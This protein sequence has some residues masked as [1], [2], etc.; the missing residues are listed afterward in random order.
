MP[1]NKAKTLAA[2]RAWE[3]KAQKRQQEEQPIDDNGSSEPIVI[4]DSE[5]DVCSWSGGVI[6]TPDIHG[7]DDGYITVWDTE[8]EIE[9]V[10][11]QGDNDIFEVLQGEEV[12]DGLQKSCKMQQ[13][14]EE[15]STP[16][17][18]ER[19]MGV[20]GSKQW[21]KAESNRALGYN[22][23]SER[24]KREIRQE[25]REKEAAAAKMQETKMAKNFHSFFT[26]APIPP[27]PDPNSAPEASNSH[28]A[29]A[30]ATPLIPVENTEVFQGYLSDIS[31]DE[32]MGNDEE[33]SGDDNDDEDEDEDTAPQAP[34]VGKRRKL[35]VSVL[36]MRA[37]NREAHKLKQ[38]RALEDIE[39]L[40][41]SKL[42]V[43]A[44][45]KNS[46][47]AY[48]ARTIQSCLWMMLKGTEKQCSFIDASRR[49]AESHK[50]SE[51][52]GGRMVRSWVTCWINT[53]ELPSSKRGCH[54]KVYSLLDDPEI[55]TELHSY[56]R[57]NKWAIDPKKL[58]LFSKQKLIPNEASKCLHQIVNTEMPTG[59]KKYM[60]L[61]LFPRIQMKVAKG[62][63]LS[64]ACCWLVK[65]G[66]QYTAHKKALY[67][68]GHERPDVVQYRQDVFVPE[69]RSYGQRLVKY[70]VGDVKEEENMGKALASVPLETIRK[71]EHRMKRWLEA[72]GNGLD[73]KGAEKQVRKFSSRQTRKSNFEIVSQCTDIFVKAFI[74]FEYG[75][76]SQNQA[77]WNYNCSF[78]PPIK[79]DHIL[80]LVLY[81]ELMTKFLGT[82]ITATA[83]VKEKYSDF[84]GHNSPITRSVSSVYAR[85]TL[86]TQVVASRSTILCDA[87]ISGSLVYFLREK[88]LNRSM[89][90]GI[91]KI[92]L[93]SINIGLVTVAVATIFLITWL[94]APHSRFTW[95]IFF[96]PAAPIY[97]NSVLVSLNA[98]K[99]IRAQM[100]KGYS[101]PHSSMFVSFNVDEIS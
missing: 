2:A 98:R 62:V 99:E 13:D 28:L 33:G 94:A 26:Q 79:F 90:I 27:P 85:G 44:A 89:R 11:E 57:S 53:R 16:T 77:R 58:A 92:T 35:N 3:G 31:D 86:I 47:Q 60:E 59:L 52:W 65:E 84:R 21:R 49:A 55:C 32:W 37:K 6:C 96:Y 56:I 50:L 78:N 22:G 46:L 72:Y 48:R 93:Y 38:K 69:M 42:D 12:I 24:R 41:A 75:S 40:I 1:R 43:F 74:P 4:S 5:D 54:S 97:V 8:E 76:R 81:G 9:S 30:T 18:Y 7:T 87:L 70:D 82:G 101:R 68:D 71:W 64:T 100:I 80:V 67:Y 45:G 14:L 95:E 34:T 51:N 88:P 10:G 19:I 25:N 20:K 61:E 15:L 23:L 91:G 36:E 66:F 73:G 83:Y 39:Q 17:S 63:S 29:N